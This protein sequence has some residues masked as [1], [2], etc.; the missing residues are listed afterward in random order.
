[1]ARFQMEVSD[2]GLADIEAMVSKTQVSSKKEFMNNAI[3]LLK[4][5]IN[6]SEKGN[7]ICSYDEKKDIYRELQMPILE[8]AAPIYNSQTTES[9]TQDTGVKV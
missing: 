9:N 2:K 6:E 4:W 8:H 1:M 3:T 7:K 5:A